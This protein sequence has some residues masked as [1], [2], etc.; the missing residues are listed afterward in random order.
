MHRELYSCETLLERLPQDL[1]DMAAELGQFIQEEHAIVGQRHL[2]RHRHLVPADQPRIRNGMMGGATRARRHQRGA[3]TG[4][5]D[6]AADARGLDGLGQG[7]VGQDGR[8]TSRQRQRASSCR[9]Q[10]EQ[11]MPECPHS[12]LVGKDTSGKQR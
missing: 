3:G 4:E 2:T 5:T 6:D 1:Q 11:I 7:H 8:E 10:Y 12:P 9:P